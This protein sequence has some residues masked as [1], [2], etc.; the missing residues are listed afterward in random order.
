MAVALGASSATINGL[1]LHQIDDYGVEWVL[2]DL[3]GWGSPASTLAP[4]Q[5]SRSHGSWSGEAWL[6]PRTVALTGHMQ[7]ND[8]VA[9]SLAADRLMD[10]VALTS[11]PLQ[12]SE[13]GRVRTMMVRRSDEVLL[14]AV[15]DTAWQW[16][17]QVTA[18]DPRKYGQSVT[19]STAL[20]ST[21][22]GLTFPLTLP[23]TIGAT[24][25]DGS[26]SIVNDGN[27]ASPLT[28]RFDGPVVGPKVVHV[29]T[30][31]AWAAT[32]ATLGAGEFW[33]VDMDR[34]TVLAQGQS[35][36]A[37]YVTERGWLELLPGANDFV[38]SAD[39]YS[40]SALM[41]VTAASAWK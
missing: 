33:T 28:V 36:R 17:V 25:V 39:T 30:Q 34:R 3:S 22:G 10:A 41:T 38:F 8:P 14:Q 6:R 26:V 35:S 15:S 4:V 40:G 7:C 29:Q 13:A 31:R 9:L 27:I 11:V 32:G 19:V 21:S 12:V 18:D 24:T 2:D 37:G 16:S 1:G 5:R 23:F 20:P